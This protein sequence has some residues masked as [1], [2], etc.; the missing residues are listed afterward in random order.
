M[1]NLKQGA[2]EF[3]Y[4]LTDLFFKQFEG[5]E[6]SKGTVYM[7]LDV[8]RYTDY[9]H[10]DLRFDGKV[11]VS[12]DRCLENFMLP[13]EGENVLEVRLTATPPKE[14]DDQE[15]LNLNEK[16]ILYVD[17]SE[18]ELDLT[19]YCYESISLSLPIQRIHPDDAD[20]K[21]LCNPEM[22]KYLN[23]HTTE[24][25]SSPFSVLKNLKN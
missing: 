22:L 14:E 19:F 9:L 7:E 5:I 16:D 20:G 3:E 21:S 10:I 24:K 18:D 8:E 1:R 11:E 6:L 13:I 25:T 17:P 4:E 23:Q 15:E 12:C 2:H